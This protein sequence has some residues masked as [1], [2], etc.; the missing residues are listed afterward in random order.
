VLLEVANQSRRC[1]RM[2]GRVSSPWS[3]ALGEV[4]TLIRLFEAVAREGELVW[5]TH[6]STTV[7]SS[8]LV[9]FTKVLVKAL[10]RF[11]P[12]LIVP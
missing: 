11:V 5:P 12:K 2:H 7:P 1:E 3:T 8:D 6:R 10:V 9:V 4:R